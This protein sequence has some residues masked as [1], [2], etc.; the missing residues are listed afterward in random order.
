MKLA[1]LATSALLLSIGTLVVLIGTMA[2]SFGQMSQLHAD[3]SGLMKLQ[4]RVNSLAL[5]AQGLLL[6]DA[7]PGFE[8]LFR[9]DC[10]D[11]IADIRE[12]AGR[13]PDALKAAT[14]LER[15]LQASSEALARGRDGTAPAGAAARSGPLALN[16]RAQATLMGISNHAI[17]ADSALRDALAAAHGDLD[18]RSQLLHVLLFTAALLFG[19]LCIA[20]FWLIRRRVSV[21][22][23][24]LTETIRAIRAGAV[25]ARASINGDDEL[26][27][28]ASGLNELVDNQLATLHTLQ[29]QEAELRQAARLR[30]LLI[31]SMPANIATLDRE[32][33]IIEVNER[34][35]AYGAANGS[36]DPDVSRGS[37]YLAVCDRAAA[38]GEEEARHVAAGLRDLISG[39]R[40]EYS[41][42]YPCHAPEERRWYCLM[43]RRFAEPALDSDSDSDSV[44]V[45]VMHVDVTERK[46]AEERLEDIAF[47]DELTGLGSRADLLQRMAEHTPQRHCLVVM[48]DL[49]GFHDINDSFG[50]A[51][52]DAV[53]HEFARRLQ[54]LTPAADAL[55]RVGGDGFV[56]FFADDDQAGSERSAAVKLALEQVLAA[57]IDLPGGQQLRIAANM[58]AF[59]GSMEQGEDNLSVLQRAELALFHA[60]SERLQWAD[61][62]RAL[63]DDATERLALT[64]DLH[65]ALE[66]GELELHFQPQVDLRS[67][68][69][70]S[71]EALLRWHHPQRGLQSPARFIPLAERSQLIVPIGAWVLREAC[72]NLRVWQDAGLAVVGVSVNVSLVQLVSGDLVQ[73][74]AAA[75]AESGIVAEQLT[76]EITETAFASDP[77]QLLLTL[78]RLRGLGV[79]LSLDDFGTGYSSLEY[80]KN[81]PFQEIKIDQSFVRNVVDDPYDQGIVRNVIAIAET[82]NAQVMAEGV[83]SQTVADRLLQLGC[84]RGQGFYY[85]M[86]ME[87]EDFRW[88]LEEHRQLPIRN[89]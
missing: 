30:E 22:V 43:A 45:V 42:E 82:I 28:L 85:S 19:V 1:R 51:T 27:E 31:N 64:R 75:L 2:W 84:H 5:P 37:N 20:A 35:E 17:A 26:A 13:Y 21:R 65:Q 47:Y 38:E 11:T 61:F 33:N 74:V 24:H 32:G 62:T 76:L 58:G 50:F 8:A 46:L 4:G 89:T 14:H 72:R 49:I 54:T 78:T 3:W 53:L 70:V 81:Y 56:L 80:L 10:V 34:W 23:T 86:P 40:Q 44:R 55:A 12:L 87:A 36:G 29:E 68:K 25:D 59:C 9:A 66:H 69:L 41:F 52:G 15:M 83:E 7:G 73:Q 48:M 60:R 39:T 71:C 57:P 18:Q 6:S 88:L 77:E 63:R 16:A 67:R 79:H